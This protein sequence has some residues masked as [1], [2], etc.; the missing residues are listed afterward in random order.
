[1]VVLRNDG[2]AIY[3]ENGKNSLLFDAGEDELAA[4]HIERLTRD[5]ELRD[6]LRENGLLTARSLSW[7]GLVDQVLALYS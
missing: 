6:G 7:D 3:L 2:N 4:H 5:A 1:M